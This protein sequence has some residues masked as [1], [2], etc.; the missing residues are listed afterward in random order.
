MRVG[1]WVIALPA[2]GCL[3]SACAAA[4]HPGR[5]HVAV[6]APCVARPAIVESVRLDLPDPGNL[7]LFSGH[8]GFTA[9]TPGD[10]HNPQDNRAYVED[11]ATRRLRL[12][13]TSPHYYGQIPWIKGDGHYAVYVYEDG[14]QD[15]GAPYMA[16]DIWGVDLDTGARRLI[17]SSHG[18]KQSLMPRPEVR[19]GLVAWLQQTDDLGRND[20]V[21]VARLDSG[22][23]RVL[24][25][26]AAAVSVGVEDANTVVLARDATGQ[27][28]DPGSPQQRSYDAFTVDV[29]TGQQ[30]RLTTEATVGAPRVSRRWLVWA[31]NDE[32]DRSSHARLVDRSLAGGPDRTLAEAPLLGSLVSTDTF[33]AWREDQQVWLAP[34][35]G[36][37]PAR[38]FAPGADIYRTLAADP[39][40]GQIAYAVGN[41]V[42]TSVVIVQP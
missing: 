23:T 42:R 19:D 27:L 30:T 11:V 4:S 31:F 22:V 6:A 5:I 21:V 16:W 10:T 8:L 29:A 18:T 15:E 26:D 7:A 39:A 34:L 28:S 32:G 36:C 20:E 3:V 17:G 35:S 2:V 24:T 1:R 33:A 14:V 13:G 40:S 38:A 37:A 12:I 9:G 41:Y 25:P